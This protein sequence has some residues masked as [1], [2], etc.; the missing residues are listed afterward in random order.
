M[1]FPAPSVMFT[2]QPNPDVATVMSRLRSIHVSELA[3]VM[4]PC[5]VPGATVEL[6]KF[7]V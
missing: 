2:D 3:P 5:G 4:N 6:K 1:R 7:L